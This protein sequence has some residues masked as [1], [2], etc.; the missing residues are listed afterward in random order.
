MSAVLLALAALQGATLDQ[1]VLVVRQDTM[2]IARERFRL[3]AT[4]RGAA[5]TG[6]TLASSIRYDRV[7]PV[8]VLAPIL[9]VGRDSLPLTLQYDVV[10][11]R[12]PTRIL[13]EA[14]P[15]R[16]TVRFVARAAERAREFPADD[17]TVVLDDSVFAIYLFAGWR[18][19]VTPA[20]LTAVF[21][22]AL[23][24]EELTIVDGGDAATTLNHTPATLRLLTLTGGANGVVRMWLDAAGRLMKI[25]IPARRL[26]VERAPDG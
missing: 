6:W 16:F 26:T 19:R 17:H 23:R 8:V 2:E 20:P 5:G 25:E 12:G 4:R 10:D 18:G 7:R 24:R 13:G 3:S 15:G 9:E 14:G 22:R 1:G 21:T 11:P